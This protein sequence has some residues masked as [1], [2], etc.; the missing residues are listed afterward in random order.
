MNILPK[1]R[2]ENITEQDLGGELLIYDLAANR[3]LNLN[4]TSARVFRA[5]D[6]QTSFEE[7]KDKYQFTDE[8]IFLT[9]E[10]LH[11]ENLLEDEIITPFAGLSRRE[12]IKKVGLGTMVALPVVSG[13]IAPTAI[14]AA[15]GCATPN[16]IT[17]TNQNCASFSCTN[18]CVAVY[19]AGTTSNGCTQIG[20]NVSCACCT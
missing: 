5:C 20:S 16:N 1:G 13:M 12:V 9:L 2:T 7:L 8:L 17:A 14:Q 10:K 15:S 11:G 6:G 4:E 3:A 18:F 19:G